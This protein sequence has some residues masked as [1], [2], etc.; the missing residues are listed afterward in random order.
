MADME[1]VAAAL[2]HTAADGERVRIGA[3]HSL[4][5]TWLMPRLADFAA[6]HPASIWHRHRSRPHAIR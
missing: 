6:R 4:T 5:Y 1:G 3:L 2:K